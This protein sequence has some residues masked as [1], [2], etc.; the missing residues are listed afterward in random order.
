MVLNKP[1]I[2]LALELAAKRIEGAIEMTTPTA[3]SGPSDR[4]I[5]QAFR[6]YHTAENYRNKTCSFGN[7]VARAREIDATN[8]PAGA[9]DAVTDALEALA[10]R[11]DKRDQWMRTKAAP[12][13]GLADAFKDA[14]ADIRSLNGKADAGDSTDYDCPDCGKR[15]YKPYRCLNCGYDPL[16]HKST[17]P[18]ATGAGEGGPMLPTPSHIYLTDKGAIVTGDPQTGWDVE[19][20]DAHNC[21]ANGCGIAHVLYR[22]PFTDERKANAAATGL[23]DAR[24]YISILASAWMNESGSGINYDWDGETFQTR[25]AAIKHG[26]ALR[27]SDDFNVGVVENG[28]LVSLDWM[29]E[30]VDSDTAALTEIAEQ[31]GLASGTEEAALAAQPAPVDASVAIRHPSHQWLEDGDE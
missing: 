5:A 20:D 3:Q 9:R 8:P 13:I 14:A 18:A 31:I 29:S 12:N 15:N 1:L 4:A 11:F 28:K 6:E 7:V 25:D 16:A 27:E 2:A 24:S 22:L 21:D 26:L 10:V 30:V 19:T 23:G 17:Q